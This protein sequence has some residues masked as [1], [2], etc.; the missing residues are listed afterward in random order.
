M[1]RDAQDREDLLRDATAF[2]ARVQMKV[3]CGEKPIE[4]FAGFRTGGR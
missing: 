2:A 4:V 1:S 3:L